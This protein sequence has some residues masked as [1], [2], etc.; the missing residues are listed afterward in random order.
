M[1][2]LIHGLVVVLLLATQGC[3]TNKQKT[4]EATAAEKVATLPF[5]EPETLRRELDEDL[6]Y[7]YLVGE[8]AAHRGELRLAQTHYQHAAILA[9]DAY[10]AERATRIALHLKDYQS[11]LAAVRRWVELAP[12][13]MTARQ[14]AAV[15]F[16]RNE[17]PE[18][19]GR[20]LDALVKIADARG[21]DGFLQAAGALS[22]ERDHAGA[23]QLLL[24]LRERHADDVRA[25]YA[26]AV[27]ETA[28]RRFD[29]AE[30]R[31]RKVIDEEP[32]WE[33]ARVLL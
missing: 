19:A 20:Q 21:T 2:K 17:Q 25:L 15:L 30:S 23:E 24:G 28:H 16:L 18:D 9:R 6:V 8:I 4:P 13:D 14:L 1:K 22:A 3:Q 12:N 26:V 7:S 31:L 29:Q 10:A 11:G 32:T 27:L 33:R 5:P